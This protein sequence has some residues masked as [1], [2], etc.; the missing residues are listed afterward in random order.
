MYS[1]LVAN[2]PRWRRVNALLPEVLLL[3]EDEREAWLRALSPRHADLLPALRT[4]LLAAVPGVGPTR[5]KALLRHFGTVRVIRGASVEELAAVPGMTKRTA[6]ELKR[7][8]A[9]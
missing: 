3:S 2:V 8:L 9:E 6:E 7:A 5:K 1:S 4:K